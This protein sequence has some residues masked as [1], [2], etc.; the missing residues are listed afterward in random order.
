MAQTEPQQVQ[1]SPLPRS[2]SDLSVP[3]AATAAVVT[4]PAA[5]KVAHVIDGVAWSYDS[6]PTGGNLKVEDGSTTIFSVDIT[7]AGPG[8][9][10]FPNPMQGTVGNAMTITLA[11]GAGAVVGKVNPLG[12]WTRSAVS[13]S[14]GG[15]SYDFSQPANSFYL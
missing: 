7:A 11:S 9:L 2:S 3:A 6:A 15:Y 14:G 12:H 5:G 8:F 4:Y 1:I 10:L 13:A